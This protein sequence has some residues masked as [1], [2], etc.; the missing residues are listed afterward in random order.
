MEMMCGNPLRSMAQL[1]TLLLGLVFLVSCVG[2]SNTTPVGVPISITLI[3]SANGVSLGQTLVVT[4]N[5]YDQRNGGAV[6]SLNPVSFGTLSNQSSTSVTYT[7][8]TDFTIATKVTITATS[9]TDPSVAASVQFTVSPIVVSVIPL[10]PQTINAGEQLLI[11]SAVQGDLNNSGVTWTLSPPSGAG[12][13]TDVTLNAATYV[14]PVTVTIPTTV[15]ITASSVANPSAQ[16]TL[17][18]TPLQ[19]GAAPNVAAVFVDGGPVKGQPR[20]NRAYTSVTLCNQGSNINCQTI[21]GILVDTGSYGLRILQSQVPLLQLKTFVDGQ[22]NLLENCVSYPDGTYIWGTVSQADVYLGGETAPNTPLQVITS[23]DV[24]APNGCSG[25]IVNPIGSTPLYNNLNTPDLL[26][27]N[28]I[29][30]IGPEPTDCTLAGKN[31]CDGSFQPLPPNLYFSCP[32]KGCQPDDPPVAVQTDKQVTNPVTLFGT[33]NN[34]TI[35]QFPPVTDPQNKIVGTLTFGIETESN[36]ALGSAT[37]YNTNRKGHF[38]TISNG[39][40]LTGSS[41]DSGSDALFFP[42][43]M[44]PCTVS[45]QFYC[46]TSLKTITVTTRGFTQGSGSVTFNVDNADTLF[47]TF[48]G[49]AA[50]GDLAGHNGTYGTCANGQGACTFDWGLPFFYGRTVYTQI[51]E[52]NPPFSAPPGPWWAF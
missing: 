36:N 49:D 26:G 15:K 51:D 41:I 3:P 47:S 4:A 23:A 16:A 34:G 33:D 46:P 6:W 35:L 9:V 52:R 27:A 21:D 5:V 20:P 28:G 25:G 19:S 50:F 38:T 1:G 31:F 18:I 10:A 32:S 29:L 44:P 45:T 24:Q 48:P 37:V 39:Q 43:V 13:L 14:A 42:G 8:P 17:E 11:N 12:S 22:G 7:A 30:G 40:T 2:G